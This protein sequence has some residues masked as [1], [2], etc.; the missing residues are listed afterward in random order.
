MLRTLFIYVS[1]RVSKEVAITSRTINEESCLTSRHHLCWRTRARLFVT[2]WL[3][4]TH[5]PPSFA[6]CCE[7]VSAPSSLVDNAVEVCSHP[8]RFQ[9]PT[10]RFRMVWRALMRR[11]Q[12]TLTV[13]PFLPYGLIPPL[14][15]AAGGKSYFWRQNNLGIGM[16]VRQPRLQRDERFSQWVAFKTCNPNRC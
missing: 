6:F 13:A 4:W 5:L 11:T 8:R 9:F 7:K 12:P 10:Q 2:L 14:T 15:N 16:P 1:A 3:S